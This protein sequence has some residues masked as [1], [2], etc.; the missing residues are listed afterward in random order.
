MM[1]NKINEFINKSVDIS[2]QMKKE[3]KI[4]HEKHKKDYDKKTKNLQENFKKYNEVISEL[5]TLEIYFE[6][7]LKDEITSQLS[8]IEKRPE[9]SLFINQLSYTTNEEASESI[10]KFIDSLLTYDENTSL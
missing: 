7:N 2:E 10:K 5:S 6:L 4:S 1:M 9:A 8:K 3:A